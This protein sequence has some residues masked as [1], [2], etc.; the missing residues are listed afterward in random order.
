MDNWKGG[1]VCERLSG[2]VLAS[3]CI[4]KFICGHCYNIVIHLKEVHEIPHKSTFVV[5]STQ[6]L[7]I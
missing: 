3:A 6:S 4:L 2:R 1:V 5:L 7:K